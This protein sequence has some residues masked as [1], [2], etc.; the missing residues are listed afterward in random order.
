MRRRSIACLLM[1]L[2]ISLAACRPA[3][4]GSGESSGASPSSPS[5]PASQSATPEPAIDYGY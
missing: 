1:V 3:D 2:A 5:A 4:G